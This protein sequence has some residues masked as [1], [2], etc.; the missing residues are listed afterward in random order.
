M[1]LKS[2]STILNAVSK[3]FLQSISDNY[4]LFAEGKVVLIVKKGF[5]WI[6]ESEDWAEPECVL[7]KYLSESITEGRGGGAVIRAPRRAGIFMKKMRHGGLFGPI[8]VDSF[9]ADRI[10]SNIRNAIALKERSVLSPDVVFVALKQ[11]S[12]GSFEG[13][14]GE[15]LKEDAENLIRLLK[16]VRDKSVKRDRIRSVAISLNDF[17]GKGFYHL[18]L[19]GGNILIK[20]TPV[21]KTEVY[22]IDLDKMAHR[23]CLGKM[24]RLKNICRLF[25]S[26][27]KFAG[28]DGF[29]REDEEFFI[30]CYCADDRKALSFFSRCLPIFHVSVLFHMLY[31]KLKMSLL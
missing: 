10:I 29:S 31:W 22:F 16:T 17:H 1:M 25:R 3:D 27:I 9:S 28:R 14:I 23:E 13:Y 12:A 6:A 18:D 8:L 11:R 7:S 2:D 4:D 26:L 20:E 30:E 15:E 24:R 21:G 5:E 19:N